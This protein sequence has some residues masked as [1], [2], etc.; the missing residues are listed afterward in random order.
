[1]AKKAR[2]EIIFQVS[3]ADTAA[4]QDLEYFKREIEN[5]NFQRDLTKAGARKV[6]AVF[7][8]LKK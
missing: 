6:T 8:W 1:M 5:G 2:L 4:I 3:D 7:E